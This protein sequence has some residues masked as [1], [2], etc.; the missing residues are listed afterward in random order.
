MRDHNYASFINVGEFPLFSHS[1]TSSSKIVF[2]YLTQI[3]FFL[4]L[5]NSTQ[6]ARTYVSA[7]SVWY[8]RLAMEVG[9]EFLK[10]WKH[11]HILLVKE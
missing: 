10:L 2:F 6:C 9:F 4:L 8:G 3:A 7:P 1:I 11:Y 5:R